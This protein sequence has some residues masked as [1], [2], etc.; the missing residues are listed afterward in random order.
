MKSVVISRHSALALSGAALAALLAVAHVG[1][2]RAHAL[3]G[4]IEPAQAK[5]P[6]A[7]VDKVS[8]VDLTVTPSQPHPGDGVAIT[9]R[10]TATCPVPAAWR[11]QAGDHVIGSGTKDVARAG[12]VTV[13]ATWLAV[14]GD[15]KIVAAVDPANLLGESDAARANNALSHDVHVAGA[16]PG[17]EPSPPPPPTVSPSPPPPPGPS[18]QRGG[19]NGTCTAWERKVGPKGEGL[20]VVEPAR[21]TASGHDYAECVRRLI[22]AVPHAFCSPAE[23]KALAKKTWFSQ[24]GEQVPVQRTAECR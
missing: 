22:G 18:G 9:F 6:C 13:M 3:T 19:A 16:A 23:R 17:P 1:D 11:V 12:V 2:A 5:G 24:A 15:T 8:A 7:S 4:G 21:A 14:Q 20:I 10:F